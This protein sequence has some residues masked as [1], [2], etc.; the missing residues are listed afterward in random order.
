MRL[1]EVLCCAAFCPMQG[2]MTLFWSEEGELYK[3]AVC[4][5]GGGVAFAR[6]S[7][8]K[9]I[10]QK[11]HRISPSAPVTGQG[12][13]SGPCVRGKDKG[14]KEQPLAAQRIAWHHGFDIY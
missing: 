11:R 9:C 3:P 2:V 5:R 8:I 10:P 4:A 14:G 7:K 6:P 1:S 12:G 13:P